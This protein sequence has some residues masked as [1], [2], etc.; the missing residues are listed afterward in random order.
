M[1]RNYINN[2]MQL[3]YTSIFCAP[4]STQY[5][6]L[7]TGSKASASTFCRSFF[8]TISWPV[9]P[10]RHSRCRR[11]EVTTGNM[12]QLYT[13]V[14][15]LLLQTNWC[16]LLQ[17]K[18]NATGIPHWPV[19]CPV[20]C[21]PSRGSSCHSQSLEPRPPWG[22]SEAGPGQ[23]LWPGRSDGW[24]S[25]RHTGW[26]HYSLKR[27]RTNRYTSHM[28]QCTDNTMRSARLDLWTLIQSLS[29]QP[30][31]DRALQRCC[32]SNLWSSGI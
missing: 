14:L 29:S 26:T 17:I 10:F 20:K 16:N 23:C 12:W 1:I 24:S 3:F 32:S 11:E 19:W 18:L 6:S 25:S 27:Y 2:D 13:T 30:P 8:T 5:S 21:Q 15:L 31:H 9:L 4:A 22:Q 7:L 28:I